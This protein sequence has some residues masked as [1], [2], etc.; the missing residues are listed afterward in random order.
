[1]IWFWGSRTKR[2]HCVTS[3]QLSVLSKVTYR[4]GACFMS[5]KNWKDRLQKHSI[6][7]MWNSW[8]NWLKILKSDLEIFLW[9]SWSC[10]VLIHWNPF[11]VKNLSESSNEAL[12]VYTHGLVLLLFPQSWLS[13]R[14]ILHSRN[15]F[16]TLPPLDADGSCRKW[17][18]TFSSCSF[19]H[20]LV[21]QLFKP[22]LWWRTSTGVDSLMNTNTSA[23]AWPSHLSCP[24]GCTK[25]C[26]FSQTW[27]HPLWIVQ[28]CSFLFGFNIKHSNKS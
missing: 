25:K 23:Y 14:K 1:M 5:S 15:L 13:F 3:C 17:P 18:C 2:T 22:C 16:V 6:T 27:T 26:N 8:T 19:P 28:T 20:S 10:W 11:M 21:S 9:E 12:K 7:I 24:S 4:W